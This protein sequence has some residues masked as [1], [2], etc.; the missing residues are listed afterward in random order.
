M[1][2]QAQRQVLAR[3]WHRNAQGGS[4]FA[5]EMARQARI[6]FRDYTSRTATASDDVR[7]RLGLGGPDGDKPD[8]IETKYLF[9][10]DSE[11]VQLATSWEP[12]ALI[13]ET[14]IM[15][16]EEGP[17]AG[18][19]VV[20]R[21]RQIEITVTHAAELVS[22]RLVS[23]PETRL[24]DVPPGDIVL[25]IERTYYAD[26]QPVETADIVISVARYAVLYGTSTWDAPLGN[27]G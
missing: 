16:P 21:M 4:P 15:L 7:R 9:R 12:L 26:A 10:G 3:S 22:A 13:R 8:V 5:I 11:P 20:D 25:T 2:E 27:C 19:G 17:H 23:T 24:L 18:K 1:R 6:G 14:P